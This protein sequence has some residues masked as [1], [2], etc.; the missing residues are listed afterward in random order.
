MREARIDGPQLAR[1]VVATMF[2]YG[3]SCESIR[4]QAMQNGL[5]KLSNRSHMWV[6]MQRIRIA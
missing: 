6:G 1:P 4:A 5:V 3:A 2:E